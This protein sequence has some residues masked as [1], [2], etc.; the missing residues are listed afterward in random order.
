MQRRIQTLVL[1]KNF[2]LVFST[3]AGSKIAAVC[4]IGVIRILAA[5]SHIKK[6]LE[7]SQR[8]YRNYEAKNCVWGDISIQGPRDLHPATKNM[9]PRK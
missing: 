5:E 9:S 6:T 2:P 8:P 3:A 4:N 7:G 1:V